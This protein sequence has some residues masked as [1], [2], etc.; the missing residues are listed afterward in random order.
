MSFGVLK[1]TFNKE[2]MTIIYLKKTKNM[3]LISRSSS[4]YSKVV[5]LFP[6]IGTGQSNIL[7][8]CEIKLCLAPY[9][10]RRFIFSCWQNH[11][12]HHQGN[13]KMIQAFP[14]LASFLVKS[15]TRW[16]LTSAEKQNWKHNFEAFTFDGFC[17]QFRCFFF[18]QGTNTAQGWNQLNEPKNTHITYIITT[19]GAKHGANTDTYLLRGR[20]WS[21]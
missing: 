14:P 10:V 20:R 12:C 3:K 7:Q 13:N 19:S 9:S 6:A 11:S 8:T 18:T 4:P 5:C 16:C 15:D 21:L 2:Y 17:K 1:N